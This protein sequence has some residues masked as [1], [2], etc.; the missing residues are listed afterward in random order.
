MNA[1]DI[2]SKAIKER[3]LLKEMKRMLEDMKF[4][5]SNEQII[6]FLDIFEEFMKSRG[7]SKQQISIKRTRNGRF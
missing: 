3:I 7:I 5:S 4:S 6:D 2:S 1:E